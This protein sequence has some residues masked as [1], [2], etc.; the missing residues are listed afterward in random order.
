MLSSLNS[1][2]SNVFQCISWSNEF[3]LI[4]LNK[5]KI[6]ILNGIVKTLMCYFEEAFQYSYHDLH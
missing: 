4:S 3:A 1:N 2:A 5:M 6:I